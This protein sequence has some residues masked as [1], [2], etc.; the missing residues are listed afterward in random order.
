MKKIL[1]IGLLLAATTAGANNYLTS[2]AYYPV[3]SSTNGAGG[4]RWQTEF[5]ITN[6]HPFDITITF[7]VAHN[8]SYDEYLLTVSGG[9]TL[10]WSDFLA[11]GFHLSGNAAV[12]VT[13]E[14]DRNP[15]HNSDCLSFSS[16]AKVYNTG[17]SG[18]T[19]GQEIPQADVLSGFLGS[20]VAYFSGVKNFGTPGSSGYRTNIGFWH[21]GFSTKNLRARIFNGAGTKIWESTITVERHKPKVVSIPANVQ[22]GVLVIDTMGEYVDC[23]VYISVVDN[24]T[25]DGAFRSMTKADP[26]DLAV[27]GGLAKCGWISPTTASPTTRDEAADR[28]H[29]LITGDSTSAIDP[30]PVGQPDGGYEPPSPPS[31]R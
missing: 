17:G 5:S 14:D 1:V 15:G 12:Y 26:D 18:G 7:Y 20:Y 29:R 3:I 27:C 9:E 4:T 2:Y 8:G 13:A 30:L 6:P 19:Y 23:A 31:E 25:G 24:R 16:G 11:N 28:L 21:T 10:T 22:A